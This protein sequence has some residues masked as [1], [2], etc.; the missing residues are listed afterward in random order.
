MTGFAGVSAF[1]V[2]SWLAAEGVLASP[3]VAAVALLSLWSTDAILRYVRHIT[4]TPPLLELAETSVEPINDIEFDGDQ[5]GLKVDDLTV[6]SNSGKLLLSEISFQIPPGSITGIIGDSGAGKSLLFQ[7][8]VDPFAL[9][10][11]R[12]RGSVRG[13]NQDLWLRHGRDHNVPAVLLPETPILLP[14]SGAN[15]LACFRD[16]AS[17]EQ[18]RHI[19]E[20]MVFS[21]EL[22]SEICECTDATTL[23]GMQKR[24]L[25][26]SR[27]FLMSPNAYLFDR[28]EDGLPEKQIAAL[29]QRLQQEARHG[30]AI[31]LATDNRALLEGCDTLIVIQDGRIIDKGDASDVRGRQA[32]GWARFVGVRNLDIDDNLE[33]WIRAQFKR[34]GDE[35]NRRKVCHIASEMLTF[36]CQSMN[37]LAQQSVIFEFKHF[38]GYCLLSL[39]DSDAPI[40]AAQL[41]KAQQAAKEPDTTSRL[42]PL[43]SIISKS[44]DVEAS[45]E[46]ER[47]RLL[48]KIETLDLREEPSHVRDQNVK[49]ES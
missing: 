1:G 19:L 33:T 21:S 47:R 16:G 20:K 4:E 23:P 9:Q 17:L 3:A 40:G 41:D 25:A 28:P 5:T 37:S 18:G 35:I 15:N 7:A 13:N 2:A 30:R 10:G 8:L 48:V 29:L 12:V 24:M 44:M 26:F 42:S 36:S 32:A 22:V 49:S 6:F 39:Q 31:M 46:L 27:A 11:L 38:V 45:A 43:A 14:T 34:P